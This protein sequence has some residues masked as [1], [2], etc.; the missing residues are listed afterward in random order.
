MRT[1][2]AIAIGLVSY[3]LGRNAGERATME[4]L[5]EIPPPGPPSEVVEV[6]QEEI[7]RIV[8]L[9][10]DDRG[11]YTSEEEIRERPFKPYPLGP[12]P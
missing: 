1:G 4:I 6:S 7:D 3:Y 12:R 5:K 9:V 11:V 2:W 10:P 8:D